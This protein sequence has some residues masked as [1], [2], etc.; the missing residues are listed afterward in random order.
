ML[1]HSR[2]RDGLARGLTSVV[3]GNS[4]TASMRVLGLIFLK[5]VSDAF[6]ERRREIPK[7]VS[8]PQPHWAGPSSSQIQSNAQRTQ[9][10]AWRLTA[11]CYSAFSGFAARSRGP[12]SS[13]PPSPSR[14]TF[15][16]LPRESCPPAAE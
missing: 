2:S 14:G 12:R 9:L 6:D 4:S 10:G 8:N 16:E 13:F 1:S 5:Y 7:L 11:F 3:S 15:G